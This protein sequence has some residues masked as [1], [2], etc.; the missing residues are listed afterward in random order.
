[1]SYCPQEDVLFESLNAEE[2]L[3]MYAWIRG[4]SKDARKSQAEVLI[5]VGIDFVGIWTTII[6]TRFRT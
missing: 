1:M 4:L 5:T 2:H 3:A 6:C